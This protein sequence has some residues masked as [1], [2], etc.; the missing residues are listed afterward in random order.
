VENREMKRWPE[1]GEVEE[2]GE[3]EVCRG[4]KGRRPGRDEGSATKKAQYSE[5]AWRA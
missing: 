1:G 2:R 3:L 4:R 5:Y